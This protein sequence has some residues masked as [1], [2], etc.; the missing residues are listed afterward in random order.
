V[1]ERLIDDEKFE[2]RVERRRGRAE[3]VRRYYAVPRVLLNE[4]GRERRLVTPFRGRKVKRKRRKPRKF[5]RTVTTRRCIDDTTKRAAKH[6]KVWTIL[7][8]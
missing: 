3:R 8:D 6:S 4:V 5:Q 7:D 2:E 1:R